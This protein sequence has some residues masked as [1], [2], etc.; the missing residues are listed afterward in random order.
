MRGGE[1]VRYVVGWVSRG[2]MVS[3]LVVVSRVDARVAH[4]VMLTCALL[5]LLS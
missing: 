3:V 1:W 4:G 2:D 5:H